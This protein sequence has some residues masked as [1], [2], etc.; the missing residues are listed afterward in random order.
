M[1][2]AIVRISHDANGRLC[3]LLA[4]P[5][6]QDREVTLF[7]KEETVC[8]TIN[9]VLKA[10][11]TGEYEIGEDGEPTEA[12]VRHWER[13]TIWPDSQCP[14][15]RAERRG[16]PTPDPRPRRGEI[17]SDYGGVTIRRVSPGTTA[18]S[19]AKEKVNIIQKLK[20]LPPEE[21]AAI[22]KLLRSS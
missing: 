9:R 10:R 22:L 5:K 15:C 4:G 16:L 1:G 3:I 21:R 13:H 18:K 17:I 8:D 7:G 20:S 6:G 19:E 2:R 14:F 11:E 12:Q